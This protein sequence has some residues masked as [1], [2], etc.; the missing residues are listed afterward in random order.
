MY[1]YSEWLLIEYTRCLSQTSK[2]G[3][4]IE[5][6]GIYFDTRENEA[7]ENS[8]NLNDG[9]FVSITYDN[10]LGNIRIEKSMKEG[11]EGVFHGK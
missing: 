6:D 8:L 5:T 7:I 9:K 10:E 11:Q 2:S 1:S 3:I 4:H